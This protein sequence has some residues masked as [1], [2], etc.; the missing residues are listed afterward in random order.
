MRAFTIALLGA[1]ALSVWLPLHAEEVEVIPLRHNLPE[2]VIPT[3]RPLLEPGGALSATQNAI[4]I[5][6]SR[7]NIDEL[8]R[9][10]A[11]VDMPPRRL[12]IYV[13]QS[14]T[15]VYDRSRASVS[16]RI[17]TDDAS[18]SINNPGNRDGV[19][20]RVLDTR[21]A[22]DDTFD[23]QVQALEGH[24]A[25]IATGQSV[26]VPMSTVT[27][28]VNGR[29]VQDSIDYREIASGVYVV[30]RVVGDRVTME[31]SPQRDTPGQYGRGSANIQHLN[32]V[33]SGR[34]GE[35]IE[36]GGTVQSSGTQGSGV[37]STRSAGGQSTRSVWVKVEELR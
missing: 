14:N 17:G 36:L 15:A 13:R 35:W 8:R 6:A 10:I 22:S 18:V 32:T 21:S 16:G 25:Y 27:R 33:A 20:A 30:P 4:V 11:S 1:L 28:T 9:V 29:I 31:I 34:L 5:R 7:K 19:H 12:M 2:Q 24:P 37:L 26:P 23:S 3:L